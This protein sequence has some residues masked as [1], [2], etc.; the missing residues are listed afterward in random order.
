[1]LPESAELRWFVEGALPPGVA[2]W[3]CQGVACPKPETRSDEYLLL[4]D[5][6]T[7]GVKLRG[8]DQ[9]GRGTFEIKALRVAP[10]PVVVG[11]LALGLM[12]CWVKWSLRSTDVVPF[13]DALR[14]DAPTTLIG[15]TRW[16]RDFALETGTPCEIAAEVRAGVGCSAELASVTVG[17]RCWWTLALESFGPREALETALLRTA[18]KLF[19]DAQL[20]VPLRLEDS[21]SYPEWLAGL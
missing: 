12:D 19:K 21:K 3:F 9:Q 2:A 5:C 13:G 17:S 20:P 6:T 4:A 10:R 15:K 8:A 1:M 7:A 16:N 14:K 11:E 18:A